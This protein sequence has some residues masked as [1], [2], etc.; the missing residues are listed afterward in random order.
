[1]QRVKWSPKDRDKRAST[2][3]SNTCMVS[4]TTKVTERQLTVLGIFSIFVISKVFGASQGAPRSLDPSLGILGTY[5]YGY[6]GIR[7][8]TKACIC[9]QTQGV[10][11]V[12][13]CIESGCV[14]LDVNGGCCNVG[15][16]SNSDAKS[17]M[18]T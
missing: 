10:S 13:Q 6:R 12:F 15:L 3:E 17:Q 5:L 14:Y 7:M 2:Q 4:H 11:R 16:Y 8:Y 9:I 1:M 18:V